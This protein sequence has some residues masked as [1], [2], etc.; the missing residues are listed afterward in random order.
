M[1]TYIIGDIHGCYDELKLLLKKIN[2][3]FKNDK[4]WITGDL[5]SRGPK[6]VEILKFLYLI[7]K[8][9]K[10]S[11]GNHDITLIKSHA[12]NY[13]NQEYKFYDKKLK[14]FLKK[15]QSQ[16]II[17]WLKK[18]K[19]IN[20]CKIKKIIMVHAGI[21]IEW[22]INNLIKYSKITE[23]IIKK[24]NKYPLFLKKI[25]KNN[26]INK[27]NPKMNLKKKIIFTLNALTRMRY[28]INNKL[29]FKY[30]DQP[31]NTPSHY[32]PWFKLK[33]NI[34]KNYKIIFGHWSLLKNF[35]LPNQFFG[36]DTGCCWGNYLTLINW[37]NKKIYK[38]KKIED[39]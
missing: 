38:Q 5:I 10:I 34:P 2:F 8:N 7:K 20:I 12:L 19:L 14:N 28:Y 11:L 13:K 32:T 24:I 33:N 23:K 27:W 37:K 17:L 30:K 26:K 9:V 3:N 15:K 29:N 16:K 31:K 35:K 6:S 1:N 4:L 25:Y 22:N 39:I 21:P 36:L 18:Q